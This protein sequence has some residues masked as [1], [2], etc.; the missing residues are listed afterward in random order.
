M[1]GDSVRLLE[2]YEFRDVL[3]PVMG[4]EEV[5]LPI[6]LQD[7]RACRH[8]LRRIPAEHEVYGIVGSGIEPLDAKVSVV[9]EAMVDVC[10]ATHRLDIL[11]SPTH[12]VEGHYYVRAA[13]LPQ[14]GAVLAVV[15]DGPYSSRSLYERLVAVVVELRQESARA[16]H[17][18][19]VLVEGVGGIGSVRAKVERREA[20]PDVVIGIFIFGRRG[21]RPSRFAAETSS[22]LSL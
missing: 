3:V 9:H 19:R 1:R 21:L 12:A 2:E 10:H 8:R 14:D 13:A 7:N 17:D 4:V 15:G 16:F 11:H 20:V 22:F 6:L 5:V 18:V